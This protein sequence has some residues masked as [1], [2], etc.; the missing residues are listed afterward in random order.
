MTQQKRINRE[1]Q[2][3]LEEESRHKKKAQQPLYDQLKT[4]DEGVV[5]FSVEPSIER[6][7]NLLTKLHS[8]EQRASL[9][10]QLQQSYGNAYV[11]RV[12]ERIQSRGN[13]PRS[14]DYKT[15]AEPSLTKT[16]SARVV[17]FEDGF[18][19]SLDMRATLDGEGAGPAEEGV[20]KTKRGEP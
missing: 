15:V 8:E 19:I 20:P 1:K 12:I 11:Q 13:S 6:H 4:P 14:S 16:D 17:I 7:A 9:V 2:E 5:D 10:T 3:E 18:G